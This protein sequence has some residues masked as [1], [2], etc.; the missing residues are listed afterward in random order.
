[1]AKKITN[2]M[3]IDDLEI[4]CV[5]KFSATWCGPCKLIKKPYEELAQ[6]FSISFYTADVDEVSEEFMEKYGV[7]T[8]PH[9]V[10][11]EHHTA[12]KVKNINFL[13]KKLD[14]LG[15]RK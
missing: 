6:N 4:P 15:L 7:R 11:V 1:M 12:E 2:E 3:S 14:E 13:E 10:L 8:L 9:I 5:I